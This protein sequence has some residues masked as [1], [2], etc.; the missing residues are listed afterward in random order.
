MRT[1]FCVN[2]NIFFA[3]L[4]KS[5]LVCS[6]SGYLCS[7]LENQ[8]K[9]FPSWANTAH[10]SS[11]SLPHRLAGSPRLGLGTPSLSFTPSGGVLCS[12]N[13]RI[14]IFPIQSLPIT[15]NKNEKCL[16]KAQSIRSLPLQSNWKPGLCWWSTPLSPPQPVSQSFHSFKF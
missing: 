15:P 11:P 2:Y 5:I 7:V 6:I 12:T 16:Y 8:T 10:M 9:D 14:T 13:C 3:R 1:I 4:C